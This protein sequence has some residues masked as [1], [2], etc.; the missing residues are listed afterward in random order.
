M[1]ITLTPE[2]IAAVAA[3]VSDYQRKNR[4]AAKEQALDEQA[5]VVAAALAEF[6]IA[7]NEE[8]APPPKSRSRSKVADASSPLA[9]G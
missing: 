7:K 8:P 2:D 5:P 6:E 3:A 4:R 9:E 1:A